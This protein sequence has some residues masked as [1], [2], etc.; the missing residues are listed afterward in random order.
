M[1]RQKLKNPLTDEKFKEKKKRRGR[2]RKKIARLTGL[3]TWHRKR[4]SI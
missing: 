4:K 3:I 1:R 2:L